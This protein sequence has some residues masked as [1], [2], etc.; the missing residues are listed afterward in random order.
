MDA[1]LN[2]AVSAAALQ[3]LAF[4]TGD[5]RIGLRLPLRT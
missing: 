4:G 5:L 3:I 2:R 1:A